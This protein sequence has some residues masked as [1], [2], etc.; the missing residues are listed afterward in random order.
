MRAIDFEVGVSSATEG[1]ADDL[2]VAKAADCGQV[3]VEGHRL[4][5]LGLEPWDA[6]EWAVQP[7]NDTGEPKT[8]A[9]TDDELGRLLNEIPGEWTLFFEVLAHSGLRIGE[10]TVLRWQDIDLGKH[11]LHVRRRLRDE[12]SVWV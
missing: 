3:P 4:P 5:P 6:I 9:L 10:A 7:T 2:D 11:R 12:A 1:L 8:K